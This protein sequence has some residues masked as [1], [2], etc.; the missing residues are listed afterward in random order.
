MKILILG[1]ICNR[2]QGLD[3]LTASPAAR[4]TLPDVPSI[5]AFSCS[6]LTPSPY[7]PPRLPA[8]PCQTYFRLLLYFVFFKLRAHTCLPGCPR[9]LAKCIYL[10]IRTYHFL[11][12]VLT[13][14]SYFSIT[15]YYS[16]LHLT[17]PYY[18]SLLLTTPYY[19]VLL[20]FTSYCF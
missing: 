5:I 3:G 2:N 15:L 6:F 19:F 4:P 18:F 7:L 8:Q 13:S 16:S 9:N 14:S 11:L 12:L 20:L 10:L 1:R 17:T